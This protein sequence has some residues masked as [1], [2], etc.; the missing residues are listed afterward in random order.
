[1]PITTFALSAVTITYRFSDLRYKSIINQR[2]IF[3][4]LIVMSTIKK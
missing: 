3:L 2:K 1:M 4:K